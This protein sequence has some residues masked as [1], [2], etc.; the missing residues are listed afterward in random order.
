MNIRKINRLINNF[1]RVL[2]RR[3][4]NCSFLFPFRFVSRKFGDNL[5]RPQYGAN[6]GSGSLDLINSVVA[7]NSAERNLDVAKSS[8]RCA[9]PSP[10]L[11][12]TA[13]RSWNFGRS[14]RVRLRETEK[15]D[16]RNRII[17]FSRCRFPRIRL[18][19]L[20]SFAASLSLSTF[21]VRHL[22]FFNTALPRVFD[23]CAAHDLLD[24]VTD[25]ENQLHDA[26]TSPL[27]S[28]DAD[29]GLGA[30]IKRTVSPNGVGPTCSV[31]RVF[32]SANNISVHFPWHGDAGSTTPKTGGGPSQCGVSYPEERRI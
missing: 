21:L 7:N 23:S 29:H 15:S 8:V 30:S 11:I 5:S 3:F 31:S 25:G 26:S 12:I 22:L 24:A 28:D 6:I 16:E 19:R 1:D 10:T 27:D 18:D 14:T 20:T 2:G 9:S 4:E 13:R 17:F 32:P